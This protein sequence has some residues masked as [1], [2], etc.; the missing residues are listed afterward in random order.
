MC[1]ACAGG[2]RL[3]RATEFIGLRR[4][5]A[6]AAGLLARLTGSR[7]RIAPF[8]DGWTLALPT[9]RFSVASSFEELVREC[10]DLID[11]RIVD[12][13]REDPPEDETD[14]LVLELAA[15]LERCEAG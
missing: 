14:A 1:G 3:S 8:G 11:Q 5:G 6:R 9:G 2:A 13:M 4:S 15:G 12:R 7:V 10:A